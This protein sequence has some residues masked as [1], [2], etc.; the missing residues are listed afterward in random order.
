[1]RY[2]SRN[3]RTQSE[4]WNLAKRSGRLVRITKKNSSPANTLKGCRPVSKKTVRPGRNKAAAQIA[5]FL[6]VR[7]RNRREDPIVESTQLALG[8]H[9]RTDR[10]DIAGGGLLDTGAE[11]RAR[12]RCA[13][14]QFAA[15]VDLV[16]L[17]R[18][19]GSHPVPRLDPAGRRIGI[20]R[21]TPAAA[22][23]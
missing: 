11:T 10:R 20:G 2:W 6:I 1:M 17:E 23:P 3:G 18:L 19:R 16:A 8:Q 13:T 21:E 15:R 14:E 7:C 9:D 12:C 4:T 5:S 22:A